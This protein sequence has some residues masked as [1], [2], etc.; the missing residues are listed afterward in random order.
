ME[1]TPLASL[2]LTHVHYVSNP[3]SLPLPTLSP[4]RAPT[5]AHNRPPEPPRPHILPLRLARPG[6]PNPLRHLRDP[7][8]VDA[9][10]R[11]PAHVRGANGLRGAQF[12]AQAVD[13]GGEAET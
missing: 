6:P 3:S 1:A 4:P 13:Q 11:D 12:S 2:S 8:L 9:R 10:S 5:P 7:D